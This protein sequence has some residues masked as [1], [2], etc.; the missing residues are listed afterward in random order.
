MAIIVVS[1]LKRTMSISVS[2]VVLVVGHTTDLVH[3]TRCR[4]RQHARYDSRIPV[5]TYN[6]AIWKVTDS[7]KQVK[8]S[9]AGPASVIY[10]V[11]VRSQTNTPE[12]NLKCHIV[13]NKVLIHMN[14]GSIIT[15]VD[16]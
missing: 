1:R 13:Q 2:T 15:S 7:I 3:H 10:N 11:K 4:G 6:H 8:I 16:G 14:N 12:Y 5:K 9:P